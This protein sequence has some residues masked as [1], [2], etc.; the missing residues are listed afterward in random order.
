MK[1]NH[2]KFLFLIMCH[3]IDIAISSHCTQI[4]K[5]LCTSMLYIKKKERKEKKNYNITEK[6]IL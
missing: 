3:V 2:N 1:R 6:N 4:K 5:Y